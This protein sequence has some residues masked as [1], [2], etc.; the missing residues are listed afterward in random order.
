M[1]IFLFLTLPLFFYNLG[2]YSLVDFDE[3]WYGEIARNILKFGQP[4]FLFFNGRPY[5]DHP[6]LGFNLMA[7]SFS[8]FGVNEFS[9]RMPSA[10]LGFGCVILTYLI[11]KTLFNRFAGLSAGLMLTSSVWFIFRAREADLDTPFL[12]FYLLCV[13]AAAKVKSNTKWLYVLALAFAAVLQVKSVIGISVLP[14]I[15]IFLYFSRT[16]IKLKNIIFSL[17]I[18]ILAIIPWLISTD[19]HRELAIGL[20][21]GYRTIFNNNTLIYLHSGIGKWYYPSL[22]SLPLSIFLIRKKPEL[23]ALLATVGILLISF[24]TNFKTEIWHLLPLYPFLFLI[25]SGVVFSFKFFRI[26]F[27]CLIIFVT[28]YQIY[29]FRYQIRLTDHGNSDLVKVSL[30]AKNRNEPLYLDGDDFFPSVVFYSQKQVILAKAA[31]LPPDNNLIGITTKESRPFL[32]ITEDWRL[33]A[34]K[35]S[36]KSYQFLSQ[37]GSWVLIYCQ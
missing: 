1:G 21:S 4:F 14:A 29:N 35:I 10:F 34:D 8:L 26:P 13:L 33:T 6:P 32:L 22:I 5:F 20:R 23:L 25:L 9:A 7:L 24:L 2:A 28:I 11:G 27:L 36:P 17:F 3:A 19:L 30:A 12:F 31:L 15:I 18:F 16:K 37:S